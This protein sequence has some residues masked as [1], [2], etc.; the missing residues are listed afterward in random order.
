MTSE[1]RPVIVPGRVGTVRH[2]LTVEVR[3]EHDTVGAGRGLERERCRAL[4]SSTPSRRAIASVTLVAL[5]VHT[6]GRK[7]PVASANPATAPVA[8]AVGVSLTANTVPDVPIETTT[9]PGAAPMP[10]A[11]AMLSPVP[12]ATG[13]SPTERGRGAR[14]LG[15]AEHAR[16][17]AAAS[18]RSRS[19]IASRSNAVPVLGRVEVAG[20]RRVTTIGDERTG[21]LQGQPVVREAHPCERAPTHRV[22]SGAATTAS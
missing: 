14:G 2:A 7:R 16:Q 18:R 13:T 11:A 20:T 21:E 4:R 19:T 5:S 9:S 1:R 10:S 15:R 3:H 22:R 8:S 6:S 12:G 17:P